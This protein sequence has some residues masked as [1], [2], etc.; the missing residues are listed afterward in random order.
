MSMKYLRIWTNL[1]IAQ[2]QKRNSSRKLKNSKESDYSQN[3]D[4]ITTLFIIKAQ[5][6]ELIDIYL[7]T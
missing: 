1:V 4:D 2:F 6:L 5:F 3:I 7:N